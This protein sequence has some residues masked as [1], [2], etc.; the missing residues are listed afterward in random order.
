MTWDS[1]ERYLKAQLEISKQSL[2]DKLLQSQA[3]AGE[4]VSRE[5]QTRIENT[6]FFVYGFRAVKGLEFESVAIVDFFT[7]E[8]D[9]VEAFY[10][11]QAA[12]STSA[13]EVLSQPEDDLTSDI[14]KAWK[15]FF[16]KFNYDHKLKLGEEANAKPPKEPELCLNG[17]RP[18]VVEIQLKILYTAITRARASLFLIERVCKGNLYASASWFKFLLDFK[19]A[20]KMPLSSIATDI[21]KTVM[22]PD[23]WRYE[24]VSTISELINEDTDTKAA[25]EILQEGIVSFYQSNMPENDPLFSRAMTHLK[26]LKAKEL[27]DERI[28]LAAKK[29]ATSSTVSSMLATSLENR[30]RAEVTVPPVNFKFSAE[31]GLLKTARDQC[32]DFLKKL[33]LKDNECVAAEAC[34]CFFELGMYDE[35]NSLFSL[36]CAIDRPIVGF[37]RR[38]TNYFD[39]NSRLNK[40][41]RSRLFKN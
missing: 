36:H 33:Y 25:I 9:K 12:A 41:A 6:R 28:A 20:T 26:A 23:E 29:Q 3:V 37:T 18:M 1:N 27:L 19:L 11:E 40:S 30:E 22:L 7:Y 38:V 5:E 39:E 17:A 2:L 24:G 14:Q 13:I 8:Q 35:L 15:Y 21:I 4:N 32:N 16:E 10:R 34:L 31:S